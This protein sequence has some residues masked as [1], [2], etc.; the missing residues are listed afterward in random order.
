MSIASVH[1]NNIYTLSLLL[2]YLGRFRRCWLVCNQ[3]SHVDM[4]LTAFCSHLGSV[5]QSPCLYFATLAA[6]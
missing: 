5:L 3:C 4:N 2:M 1:R 6:S